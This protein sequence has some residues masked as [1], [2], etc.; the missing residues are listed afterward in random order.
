MKANVESVSVLVYFLVSSIYTEMRWCH[1]VY[2]NG[3]S[4]VLRIDQC[5][6]LKSIFGVS[7][8]FSVASTWSLC[9]LDS[10]MC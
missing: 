4:T 1:L 8:I 2:R 7:D 6:P 5:L 3:F 10:L 9:L